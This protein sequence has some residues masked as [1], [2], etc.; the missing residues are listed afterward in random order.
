V[1]LKTN[2]LH[3]LLCLHHDV[4]FTQAKQICYMNFENMLFC[5]ISHAS[6]ITQPQQ[7]K[8]T[9]KTMN[10]KC[11]KIELHINDWCKSQVHCLGTNKFQK[12]CVFIL[13]INKHVYATTWVLNF[14]NYFL[15]K[16]PGRWVWVIIL[17][18]HP[19]VWMAYGI[20][21][22][23]LLFPQC[24]V[25]LTNKHVSSAQQRSIHTK[26]QLGP[27]LH[28]ILIF[29]LNFEL[30]LSSTISIGSILMT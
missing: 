6:S 17:W 25:P 12:S 29:W 27:Q 4:F 14:L 11:V 30:G 8:T 5:V 23:A 15:S 22:S 7:K 26:W 20:L 10:P 2:L 28:I 1:E 9:R 21:I 3:L 19:Y 16:G 13:A 24:N 18:L